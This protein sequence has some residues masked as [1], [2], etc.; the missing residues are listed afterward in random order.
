MK[1]IAGIVVLVFL[2]SLVYHYIMVVFEGRSPSYFH[3]TQVVVETFTGT[4]YGS[5][6][7]LESVVGNLFVVTM[8]LSTGLISSIVLP[9]LPARPRAD[10]LAV[11]ADGDGPRGSRRGGCW[12]RVN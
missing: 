11:A 4:G 7:P 6:S 12:S 3:S 9:Y 10:A 5:D 8:D 2:T 1:T